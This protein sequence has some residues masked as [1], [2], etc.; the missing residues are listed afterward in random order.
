MNVGDRFN[1]IEISLEAE[2]AIRAGIERGESVADLELLGL[3]LRVI[4]QLEESQFE[5]VILK[6]L[7]NC[8]PDQLLGIDCL[9]MVSVRQILTALSRY[10]ELEDLRAREEETL[11]LRTKTNDASKKGQ[12]NLWQ[13]QDVGTGRHPSLPMR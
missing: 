7:M 5:I 6:Q 8:T 3:P 4:N 11:R 1:G 2:R 13:L 12:Q 9:A 10:H